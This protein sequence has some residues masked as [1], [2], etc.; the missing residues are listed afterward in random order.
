MEIG[1]FED[2]FPIEDRDISASYVSLL[3]G[4]MIFL[5]SSPCD[6]VSVEVGFL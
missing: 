1:P 6:A 5:N 3:A 4:T 2:V